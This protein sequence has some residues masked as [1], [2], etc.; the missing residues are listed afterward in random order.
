MLLKFLIDAL[1]EGRTESLS[2]QTIGEAIF[3]RPT[4]YNTG[5]DNIVRVSMRNLREKLE[6]FYST[7]GHEER[8][9]LSIPKGKYI[10]VL[11]LRVAEENEAITSPEELPTLTVVEAPPAKTV[12]GDDRGASLHRVSS[13]TPWIL[14]I[15][16]VA[17]AAVLA[18]RGRTG[19]E[20]KPAQKLGSIL[21]LLLRDRRPTTVVVTDANLQAYRMIFGKTVSLDDYI[22]RSYEREASQASPGSVA[23]GAWRYVVDYPPQTSLTSSIVAARIT[24]AAS[25]SIVSI[26][27]PQEMGMR[28][29]EHNNLILL[30]GP[31]INPWEQLFESQLNFRLLPMKDN[32]LLTE[33]HNMN[34]LPSEP[35][36]FIPHRQN[37]ATVNY[38]RI[39]LPRNFSDDGYIVLLGAASEES[40]EAAGSFL[41]ADDQMTNWLGSFKA[42]SAD[43]LPSA[44]IVIE[45]DG[46]SFVPERS[47]IVASRHFSQGRRTRG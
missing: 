9:I 32:P 16:L 11:N 47:K 20:T 13:V 28:D 34:P 36:D 39:A 35:A 25:P 44:E 21:S 45:V 37:T 22:D 46:Y 3:D 1:E 8:F 38:V 7:D 42:A 26:K 31:W 12:S 40:L 14:V 4:G 6:E 18:Y 29:F 5:E 33:I 27:S 19:P 17:A 23:A 43:Q 2:E 10:P 41:T 15:L 24:A 30:G